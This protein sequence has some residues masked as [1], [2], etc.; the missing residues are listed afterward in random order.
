M[1]TPKN[2]VPASARSYSV[3]V[4]IFES[5]SALN[6]SN[7]CASCNDSRLF[8]SG[9]QTCER[10]E[11]PS[12][13]AESEDRGSANETTTEKLREGI[14]YRSKHIFCMLSKTEQEFLRKPSSFNSN[15]QRSLRR[16]LKVKAEKMRAELSLLGIAENCNNAT[17]F[18]SNGKN[19]K[20]DLS[21]NPGKVWSLRRDLDPRPLPYQG[22]APPG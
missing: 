9:R 10:R 13:F 3:T 14:K 1:F 15:Y 18:C 17:E 20:Q 6:A 11:G 19:S 4:G 16:R 12:F 21:M 7:A 22:N 2:P 8:R 5:L